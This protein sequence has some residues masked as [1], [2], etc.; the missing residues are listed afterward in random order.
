[1]IIINQICSKESQTQKN[2]T[3]I[4]YTKEGTLGSGFTDIETNECSVTKC[5]TGE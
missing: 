3:N 1:M 5:T 4:V 2:H